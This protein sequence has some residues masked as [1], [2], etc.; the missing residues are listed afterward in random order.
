M[1]TGQHR[2][3]LLIRRCRFGNLIKRQIVAAAAQTVYTAMPRNLAQP[4]LYVCFRF[5]PGQSPEKL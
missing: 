2:I 1:T 4:R 5:E 3:A